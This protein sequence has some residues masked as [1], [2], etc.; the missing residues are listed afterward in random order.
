MLIGLHRKELY[1][2][3]YQKL[4]KKAIEDIVCDILDELKVCEVHLFE[5]FSEM[6]EDILYGIDETEVR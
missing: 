5:K 1:L 4:R 3:T 6:L 2:W